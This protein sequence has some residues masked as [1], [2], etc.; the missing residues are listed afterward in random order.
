[1]KWR[2]CKKL[3]LQDYNRKKKKK[4]KRGVILKYF[5]ELIINESFKISFWF[6]VLSYLQ[7][8]KNIIFKFAYYPLRYHYMHL[9]RVT[10]F[11]LPIG[12]NVGGGLCFCHFGAVVIANSVIIGKNVSIHPN[13][14]IGRA[15]AGKKKGTPVIGDNVV[16][17]AGAKIIGNVRVGD[18]VV[19]GSNAVVVDDIPNDS[20]VAGVPAKIVSND[21][22][23]CFDEYWG[24][25]FEHAYIK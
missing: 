25:V 16:I 6:R 7:N 13:V 23:K 8:K 20:V 3:I 11:Q 22:S 24:P 5:S 14:T 12:T 10:G 17:F 2:E 9:S 21:S 1:M 18:N 19:I 15:F 4:L